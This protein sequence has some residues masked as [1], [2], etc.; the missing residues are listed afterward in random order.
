MGV[1]WQLKEGACTFRQL[2]ERCESVPPATLNKRIKELT[3]ARLIERIVHGYILTNE[4][5]DLLN[6]IK[7]LKEWS[8]VWAEKFKEED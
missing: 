6:R 1:I 7:P 3:E 2:Q 4:G 8:Y 5:K